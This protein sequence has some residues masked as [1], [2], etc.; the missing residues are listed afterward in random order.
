[1]IGVHQTSVKDVCVA[2]KIDV[3]I[4]ELSA[5]IITHVPLARTIL[6]VHGVHH[7]ISAW[8]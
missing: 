2:T 4:M 7:Q 8:T 3:H 1:V 5:Q 6:P